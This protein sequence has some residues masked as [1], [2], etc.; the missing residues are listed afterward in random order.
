[1]CVCKSVCLCL[2]VCVCVCACVCMYCTHIVM[3]DTFSFGSFITCVVCIVMCIVLLLYKPSAVLYV[4]V[5]R[6]LFFVSLCF[7]MND[8]IWASP[9]NGH[10]R[11]VCV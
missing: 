9:N 1:M 10:Y 6:Y 5:I 8:F 11:D 2:C 4:F 3:H 7:Y